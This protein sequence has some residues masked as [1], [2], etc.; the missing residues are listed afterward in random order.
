MK[1]KSTLCSLIV[2]TLGCALYLAPYGSMQTKDQSPMSLEAPKFALLVGINEYKK[3]NDASVNIRDL[4]GTHNDV[5]LMKGL[6]ADYGFKEESAGGASAESPCGQQTAKSSV[7]TLCSK[8]ATQ[9]AIRDAFKNHLIANAKSY[10]DT[11]KLTAANRDKGVT[12][13]FYYSGHGSKLEDKSGDESD[14]ID[15]TI[16][17]HDSD[18]KGVKDIPDDDFDVFYKDLSQYTTNITFMFDSC[19]SGTVTRGGSPKS[20]E[21]D[22]KSKSNSR[23][24]TT[25]SDGISVSSNANYVTI[26]GSLPTQESQED[27]LIDPTT[28]REQWNGALTFNFVHLLRQNPDFTYRELIN[29]IQPAVA[30]FNQTPQAEG[31][32][33]RRI[34]GSSATR[35]KVSIAIVGDPKIVKKTFEGK[36]TEVTEVKL[37]VGAI[38]GAGKDAAIVVFGRKAGEKTREQIG[39]GIVT[40][41]TDFSSTAEIT[42]FS[43]NTNENLKDAVVNL[44]S[45]SFNKDDKQ[46]IALD[47]NS[48]KGANSTTDASVKTIGDIEARLK[49]NAMLKTVRLPNLLPAMT[50][51]N[52]TS[53]KPAGKTDDWDVAVVRA[54]YKDFKFGNQQPDLSKITG[55]KGNSDSCSQRRFVDGKAVEP[56]DTEEG[57]FLMSSVSKMPLYNI[58]YAAD[59]ENAG[60]CLADALLKIAR[61]ENLR[62][63]TSGGSSLNE[64]VKVELVRLSSIDSATEELKKC[65]AEKNSQTVKKDTSEMPQLKAGDYFYLKMTNA[66]DKDLFVYLYSLTTSGAIDLIYPPEGSAASEKFPAGTTICTIQKGIVFETLNLEVSPPGVETLKIIATETE[67]PANLLTQ[68]EIASKNVARGSPLNQLLTQAATGTRTGSAAFGV[69]S[70]ATKNIN[71]EIVP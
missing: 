67:F 69:S 3:F 60:K 37:G 38:V 62:K 4:R 8:Q 32:I 1:T 47:F 19:H 33:D 17:A 22:V 39:S 20:V 50:N 29:M 18:R 46:T 12:V 30:K 43:K 35:G 70:W 57:Y 24:K 71:I 63:L 26:S 28:K 27:Q 49:D 41:A 58:W 7:K 9:A 59:N 66:S 55:G 6:L 48:G 65:N 5:G 14:G 25:L 68:P 2:L 16:V 23:G 56:P 40:S 51:R 31:D 42:L 64:S 54:T 34:F 10:F 45:P 36:E 13:V 11:Q 44:V 61:I 53:E 52:N 21:R 15:E